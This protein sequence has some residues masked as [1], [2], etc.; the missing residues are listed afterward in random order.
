M[1]L[2]Q[3]LT[4]LNNSPESVQFEDT[5]ATIEANYD[6]QASAFTNGNAENSAEQ[7]QGSC[8]LLAFAKL[9]GFSVEQTLACFG[10]Y[11]REDVLGNPEGDDHQNIRQFM[12]NGWDG[13][14]F[15]VT[16]LTA[17]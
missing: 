14:S 1:Q 3:F 8:K 13:V 17:K 15:A 11:Y 9:Q 2:E 6:Y 5:M 16:P 10:R 7:N 4:K 12:A